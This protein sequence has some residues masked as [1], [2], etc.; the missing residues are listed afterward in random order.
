MEIT[1][2]PTEPYRRLP[3]DKYTTNQSQ[4]HDRN[5]GRCESVR[6]FVQRSQM[7]NA[8]LATVAAPVGGRGTEFALQGDAAWDDKLDVGESA[9]HSSGSHATGLVR[10]PARGGNGGDRAIL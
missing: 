4:S 7:A 10:Q 3:H 5:G 2:Q 8:S 6:C 9:R 1:S